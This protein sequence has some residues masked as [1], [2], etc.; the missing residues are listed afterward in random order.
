MLILLYIFAAGLAAYGLVTLFLSYL[1]QQL[2]RNP[3]SD[4]PD[5]GQVVDTKITACDGGHLEVWRIEP[6]DASIGIIVLAHGW[7]RNRDRMMARARLFAGWGFTTVVHSARDHGSS[8]PRRCMNAL[9][10]AED[11]ESVLEWVEE[12]VI[13]YGHSAGAAA[14][15]IAAGRNPR[16]I[17]LL[18]LEACYA[19]TKEALR[20]LYRWVNPFFGTLFGPMI[21][22]WMDLFYKKQLDAVSPTRIAPALRMPVMLIHGE[23]DRRFPLAF[24]NEL[25]DSFPPGLAD[26]YIAPGA[27][28]SDSS[29]TPGYKKAVASFLNRNGFEVKMSRSE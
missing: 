14:A 3:V 18:F 4:P 17:R 10:M 7:G 25:H 2:P 9:R 20:S 13:L 5:W 24:A 21:V 6:D 29:Q 11:I 23:K 16:K 19:H 1:V 22:F 15:I 28:H 26:F 8:S 12:P 27:G